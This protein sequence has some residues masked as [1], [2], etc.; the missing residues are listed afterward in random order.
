MAPKPL[1]EHMGLERHALYYH[2]KILEDCGLVTKKQKENGAVTYITESEDIFLDQQDNEEW[3][4]VRRQIAM[5]GLRRLM[6]RIDTA[7]DEEDP[8]DA[9]RK[10]LTGFMTLFLNEESRALLRERLDTLWDDLV[11]L[12][13]PPQNGEKPYFLAFGFA[14]ESYGQD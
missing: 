6:G 3:Q 2:L 10:Y 4:A 1:Q 14:P 13:H 7:L 9:T 5:T 8:M 12:Q 11:E